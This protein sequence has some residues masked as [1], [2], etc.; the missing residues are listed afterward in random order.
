[1]KLFRLLAVPALF[2]MATAVA[3]PALA[4]DKPGMVKAEVVEAVV[5]V[6]AVDRAARTVTLKGPKGNTVTLAVPDEAQNFDQIQAG[7]R[8]LVR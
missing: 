3:A 6:S 4:Q 1:M 2:A 7:D 5:N 8:V